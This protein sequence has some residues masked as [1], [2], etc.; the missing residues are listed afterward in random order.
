MTVG[1]RYG[2][3]LCWVA[4]ASPQTGGAK[5]FQV[6]LAYFASVIAASVVSKALTW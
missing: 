2:I 1:E 6:S 5:P 3:G 4:L